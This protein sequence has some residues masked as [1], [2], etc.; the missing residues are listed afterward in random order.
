MKIAWPLPDSPTK[1]TFSTHLIRAFI[2]LS[3]QEQA[4]M[5]PADADD[6]VKEPARAAQCRS[7]RHEVERGHPQAGGVPGRRRDDA[8]TGPLERET[9]APHV[10]GVG[11]QVDAADP[12]AGEQIGRAHV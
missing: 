2:L 7:G 9:R 3:S 5:I 10:P 11:Y 12:F 8:E 6:F 4:Q 1:A